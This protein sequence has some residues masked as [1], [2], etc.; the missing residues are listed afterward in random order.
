[1]TFKVKVIAKDGLKNPYIH[2]YEYK[3]ESVDLY[4]KDLVRELI[5]R[6]GFKNVKVQVIVTN[7]S[8]R[9]EKTI[10]NLRMKIQSVP[11]IPGSLPD[12]RKGSVLICQ[13]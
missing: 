2:T 1:M 4:V 6:H 13:I 5:F 3:G 8:L 7:P 9:L 12:V 11:S 10:A